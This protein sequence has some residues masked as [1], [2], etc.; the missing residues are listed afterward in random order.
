MLLCEVQSVVVIETKLVFVLNSS[1]GPLSWPLDPE[2]LVNTIDIDSDSRVAIVRDLFSTL[3]LTTAHG[4]SCIKEKRVREGP[5][6]RAL[7]AVDF[8]TQVISQILAARAKVKI[9]SIIVGRD[10]VICLTA[11]LGI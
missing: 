9:L 2:I 5:R 11:A 6:P 10:E 3:V 7:D 8:R 4:I 1:F